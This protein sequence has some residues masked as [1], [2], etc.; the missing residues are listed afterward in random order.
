MAR[1]NRQKERR[2]DLVEAARGAILE[3]GVIG[4]R[5]R[6]VAERA[7]ISASA[8]FYYYPGLD[9]L[10]HDVARQAVERFCTE[11]A[12][13]VAAI[14][15]PR[16]RLRTMIRNGLPSGRDDSLCRLL[17]ELS[18]VARRDPVQAARYIALYERQ[19]AIYVGILEAGVAAG[20]FRLAAEVATIA[21]NLVVLEDGYGLHAVMA[22]PT[23][24]VATAERLIR[25]YAALAVGCNLEDDGLGIGG[26]EATR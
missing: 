17:Y 5:L 8:L 16:L 3:R 25:S 13:A 21:R 1:P 6:D 22:V 26:M 23:F 18:T 9:E 4:L 24:D 11:R 7:G 19:V 10:L 2:A 15:D 20:V 14:A 12:Q